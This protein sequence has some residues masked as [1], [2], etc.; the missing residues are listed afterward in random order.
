MKKIVLFLAISLALL[1]MI[2]SYSQVGGP[3]ESLYAPKNCECGSHSSGIYY[4]TVGAGQGCCSGTARSS[5]SYTTYINDEGVWTVRTNRVI[6]GAQAQ[7]ACCP[8]P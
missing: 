2:F 6:T 1:S 7:A 3:D 4:Y 8:N 5:G